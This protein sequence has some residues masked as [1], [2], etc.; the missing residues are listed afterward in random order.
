[1]ATLYSQVICSWLCCYVMTHLKLVYF[2]TFFFSNL[3]VFFV[4]HRCKTSR[5]IVEVAIN[6]NK[7][8]G[9]V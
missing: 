4:M 6:V 9:I 7:Y 1:M 2:C 5:C 3:A 8:V